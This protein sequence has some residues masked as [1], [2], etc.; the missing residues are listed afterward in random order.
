MLI[1]KK[2]KKKKNALIKNKHC[3][4]GENIHIYINVLYAY[5]AI[6]QRAA[7]SSNVTFSLREAEASEPGLKPRYS[8]HAGMVFAFLYFLLF[9]LYCIF[10]NEAVHVL[11]C[12]WY[13]LDLVLDLFYYLS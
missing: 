6:G 10:M 8:G 9:T 7:E 11:L 13:L 12:T 5:N 3:H 1:K 2:K 4:E